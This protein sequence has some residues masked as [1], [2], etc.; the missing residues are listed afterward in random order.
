[1]LITMVYLAS[2][3]HHHFLYSKFSSLIYAI[4]DSSSI[5]GMQYIVPTTWSYIVILLLFPSP[6]I[7]TQMSLVLLQ[8]PITGIYQHHF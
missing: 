5:A 4:A 7:S 1:M 3:T 2:E 8:T 6:F